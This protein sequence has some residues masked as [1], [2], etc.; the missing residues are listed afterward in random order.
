M[1][2]QQLPSQTPGK[3]PRKRHWYNDGDLFLYGFLRSNYITAFTDWFMG[4][5]G[6][7]AEL[8]LY[9]TVLY[10]GAELY[11]GVNLPA[12]LNL[13]VFI[14]QLGALD[15]GGIGL[16]KLARQARE[17]QNAEGAEK[18]ERLSRWLIRIMI[19]GIVTVSAE[20]TLAH[21]PGAERFEPYIQPVQ[22][23]VELALVVARA[24]CAVLYGKVVHALKPNEQAQRAAA[25]MDVEQALADLATRLDTELSSIQTQMKQRVDG[26][27]VQLDTLS[28]RHRSGE[29]SLSSHL[30]TVDQRLDTLSTD[31]SRLG[32]HLDRLDS[33][34][35]RVDRLD[36]QQKQLDCLD[37]RLAQIEAEQGE[38]WTN[39]HQSIQATLREI[40]Q[41]GRVSRQVRSTTRPLDPQE[42]LDRLD[43]QEPEEGLDTTSKADRVSRQEHASG[44]IIPLSRHSKRTA[45]QPQMT[46][47][48]LAFIRTNQREPSLGE[49]QAWGCAKQTAVNS[50][51]AARAILRQERATQEHEGT[52]IAENTP[53]P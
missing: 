45:K 25:G 34:L 41:S 23:L 43:P 26:L 9:V 30:T 24:V 7:L 40:Q 4:L 49:I 48:I 35:S 8:V 31:L 20:Q 33:Q 2:Q 1:L 6:K 29:H 12:G 51:E 38:Q 36:T 10:S 15:V 5:A 46:E 28:T 53:S 47:R 32:Q 18:A 52:R 19:A 44:K 14:L 13:S 50:R 11:P 39:L 37:S 21:L 3:P 22:A 27:F 16:S 42:P 17:D